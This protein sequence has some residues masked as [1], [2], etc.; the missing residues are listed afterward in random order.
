MHMKRCLFKASN[1]VSFHWMKII[2]YCRLYY[3]WNSLDS[4]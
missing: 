2:I 4:H 3:I 1:Q